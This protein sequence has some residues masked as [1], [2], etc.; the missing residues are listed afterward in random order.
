MAL[1]RGLTSTSSPCPQPHAQS[2]AVLLYENDADG[3]GA[4][5]GGHSLD[6]AGLGVRASQGFLAGLKSGQ[7]ARNEALSER[8]KND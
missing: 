4:I 8:H 7:V 3:F 2:L 6:L 5:Q 1:T